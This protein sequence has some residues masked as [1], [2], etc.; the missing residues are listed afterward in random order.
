[1]RKYTITKEK[2]VCLTFPGYLLQLLTVG[3]TWMPPRMVLFTSRA[4]PWTAPPPTGAGVATLSSE[5]THAP[6]REMATGPI[7]RPL[8]SGTTTKDNTVK[9]WTQT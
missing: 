8:V 9:I 3:K 1:M 6:A 7:T 5:T 4:P 2:L